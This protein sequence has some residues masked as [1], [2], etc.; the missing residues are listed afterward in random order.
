MHTTY[1]A[2]ITALSYAPQAGYQRTVKPHT[3]I[4]R[5]E[6]QTSLRSAWEKLICRM[7]EYGLEEVEFTIHSRATNILP[8][9]EICNVLRG[10]RSKVNA[11]ELKAARAALADIYTASQNRQ[12]TTEEDAA[13][14]ALIKEIH[15][16]TKAR[17]GNQLLN[18]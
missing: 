6:Q 1:T 9:R 2:E 17:T 18:H 12:L 14:R 16:A 10:S 13:A 11:P 8:R 3:H 4:P 5:T 7:A 15:A